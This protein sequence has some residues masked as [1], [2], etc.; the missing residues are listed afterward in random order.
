MTRWCTRLAALIASTT[1]LVYVAAAAA[2][3]GPRREPIRSTV[4]PE[5]LI[6]PEQP[7]HIVQS[8]APLTGWIVVAVVVALVAAG[9]VRVV[10]TIHWRHSGHAHAI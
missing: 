1:A 3:A 7:A 10:R 5:T 4:D 2:S 9:T 6:P 8:G